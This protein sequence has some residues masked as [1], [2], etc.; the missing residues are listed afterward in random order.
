MR[1]KPFIPFARVTAAYF[2]LVELGGYLWFIDSQTIQTTLYFI[3]TFSALC[4][5][6]FLPRH[7]LV[8]KIIRRGVMLLGILALGFSV[9]EL[10]ADLQIID[11]PDYSAAA[12]RLIVCGLISLL[13][14]ESHSNFNAQNKFL[15]RK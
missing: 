7:I 8:L 5:F 11:S 3:T 4:I 2:G 14:W 10:I 6:V 9:P 1:L 12:L 13:L 15:S